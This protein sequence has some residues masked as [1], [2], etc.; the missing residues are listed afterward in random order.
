MRAKLPPE[1][2]V[3]NRADRHIA[4]HELPYPTYDKH[5]AVL[6]LVT[7][8]LLHPNGEGTPLAIARGLCIKKRWHKEA[9][10]RVIKPYQPDK[11]LRALAYNYALSIAMYRKA[12]KIFDRSQNLQRDKHSSPDQEIIRLLMEAEADVLAT[13]HQLREGWQVWTLGFAEDPRLFE[14][15]INRLVSHY[16][17]QLRES[18]MPRFTKNPIPESSKYA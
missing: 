7:A 8:G 1:P 6:A 11:K 3:I 15:A 16:G 13:C 12:R 4:L 14:G 17:K 5:L 2:I 9:L 18:Y 10:K